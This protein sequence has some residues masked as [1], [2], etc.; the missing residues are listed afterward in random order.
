MARLPRS[1]CA[2]HVYHVM[3]RAAKRSILFANA[4]DYLLFERTLEIA[5]ARLPMRLLAYCLMPTHWHL[6]LW[7]R[8][9]GE[10][11]RFMQWLTATHAQRWNETNGSIGCGAVYQSRF[12]CIWVENDEHLLRV[13]RYIERNPL[14]A[15]LVAQAEDWRWCSLWRRLRGPFPCPTSLGPVQLPSDWCEL[16]NAGGP[17]SRSRVRILGSDPRTSTGVRRHR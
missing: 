6:L 9:D 8:Q 15:D 16:L 4:S 17:D 3:N 7:P 2:N 13:W 14:A 12:R 11:S 10:I 5:L 1:I